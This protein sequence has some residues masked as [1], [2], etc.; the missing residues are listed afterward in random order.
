MKVEEGIEV[1]QVFQLGERYSKPMGCYYDDEDGNSRPMIMGTYGIGVTRLMAAV[2]EQHHDEKGIIWPLSVAPFLL[3]ILPLDYEKSRVREASEELRR[4]CR[5][6]G[7]EV[8]LDDR[9]ERVGVKFADADLL[10]IPYRAVI[11]KG[12]LEDGTYEL[13]VRATGE[14]MKTDLESVLEYL[15]E[16]MESLQGMD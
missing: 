12:Y 16:A 8:L 15:R 5:E 3:H 2:V 4:L 10:G 13:Q 9:M 1:G 11:G 6:R 7:W 14:K